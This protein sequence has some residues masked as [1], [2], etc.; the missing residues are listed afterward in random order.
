MASVGWALLIVAAMI[1]SLLAAVGIGSLLRRNDDDMTTRTGGGTEVPRVRVRPLRSVPDDAADDIVILPDIPHVE[2]GSLAPLIDLPVPA[3]F[4]HAELAEELTEQIAAAR[5]L[6]WGGYIEAADVRLRNVQQL[7]QL[8]RS[9][10][11]GEPTP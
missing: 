7:I 4:G 5:T 1:V 6:M 2:E 10:A 3:A 9:R 11:D 8:A